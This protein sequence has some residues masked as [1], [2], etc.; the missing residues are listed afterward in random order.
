VYGIVKNH[1][2]YIDVQ[3]EVGLGTTFSVYLPAVEKRA[4]TIEQTGLS[5]AGGN[6]T[7]LV[8][9]DEDMIRSLARDILQSKGY[10]VL[11][12]HDGPQALDLYRNHGDT[13]D[14]VIL[15]MAMPMMSGSELFARLKMQNE[16]VK[17]ILSTGYSEDER[18]RELMSLGVKAF[19]Q[20]PY[21][22]AELAAV[23]RKVL[24]GTPAHH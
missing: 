24:D 7:I 6:E 20:K 23:V 21:R 10:T 5:V 15:D 19:V 4:V 12:A 9:D 18:A 2:G 14:L 11:E 1:G 17:T 3:S 22:V 16:H 13:I 8:V